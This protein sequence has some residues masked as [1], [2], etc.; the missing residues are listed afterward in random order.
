[1][2]YLNKTFDTDVVGYPDVKQ[3]IDDCH[4]RLYLSN[5]DDQLVDSGA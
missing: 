5:R 2:R 3:M 1:M 4:G